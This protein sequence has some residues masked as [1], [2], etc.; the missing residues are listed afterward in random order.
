VCIRSA[1]ASIG[2]RNPTDWDT[3]TSTSPAAMLEVA[4]ERLGSGFSGAIQPKA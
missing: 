3:K 4:E 2:W 1:M